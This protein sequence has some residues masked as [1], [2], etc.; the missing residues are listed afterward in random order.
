MHHFYNVKKY[1]INIILKENP[2]AEK[3]HEDAF[4]SFS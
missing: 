3:D 4:S 2:R 1:V